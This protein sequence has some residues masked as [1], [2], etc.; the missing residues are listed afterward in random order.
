MKKPTLPGPLT[1]TKLQ[2]RRTN[3]RDRRPGVKDK[4]IGIHNAHKPFVFVVFVSNI[5]YKLGYVRTGVIIRV[6][7]LHVVFESD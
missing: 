3:I 1:P 7:R 2:G 5:M 6:D 4:L